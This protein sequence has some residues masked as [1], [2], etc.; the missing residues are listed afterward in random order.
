M[1]LNEKGSLF[2]F[3]QSRDSIVNL[4]HISRHCLLKEWQKNQGDIMK[5]FENFESSF[6]LD[7]S[8]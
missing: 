3:S 4:R 5:K 6:Y 8:E 7:F 2:H 1:L